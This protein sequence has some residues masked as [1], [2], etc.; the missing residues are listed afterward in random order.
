MSAYKEMLAL[1]EQDRVLASDDYLD[2]LIDGLLNAHLFMCRETQQFLGW[3]YIEAV[4]RRLTFNIRLD[5]ALE[6]LRTC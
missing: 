1:A 6:T 4:K 2:E 5:K 3:A